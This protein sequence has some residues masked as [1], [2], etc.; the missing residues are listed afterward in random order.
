M[1]LKEVV[2]NS[3]KNA[4]V[5]HR[6]VENP[7][8]NSTKFIV[9]CDSVKVYGTVTPYAYKTQIKRGDG[10]VLDEFECKVKN[11]DDV[12][13][14]IFENINTAN[15]LSK[16]VE[17]CTDARRNYLNPNYVTEADDTKD[18]ED[19]DK[20][21]LL[22]DEEI[23]IEETAD[24]PSTLDNLLQKSVDLAVEVTAT[25]DMLPETDIE[26]RAE[27][28]TLASN[29]YGIADDIDDV[30]DELYPEEEEVNESVNRH[31]YNITENKK[32]LNKLSEASILMRGKPEYKS[33]REALKLIKSELI[34]R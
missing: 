24:L 26:T 10:T 7:K 2:E 32:I 6:I 23:E 22:S 34:I 31:K 16:Y 25:I 20:Q 17:A 3:L 11:T 1:T 9:E 29:F 15:R 19:D 12:V 21:L 30:I 8:S 18:D 13:N 27:L 28:V 4:G 5:K 33:I 14:R